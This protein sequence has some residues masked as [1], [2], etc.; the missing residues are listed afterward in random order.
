MNVLDRQALF[1]TMAR[2]TRI[3]ISYRRSETD[4]AAPLLYGQLCSHFGEANVFMDQQGLMGGDDYRR[5]IVRELQD[6]DAMVVVMGSNWMGTSKKGAQNRLHEPEDYVRF[7]VGMAIDRDILV[8]PVLVNDAV[9]PSKQDLPDTLW[10][11]TTYN[12]MRIRLN[13]RPGDVVQRLVASIKAHRA[14]G[15]GPS[16]R[17]P[18]WAAIGLVAM[19]L[20]GGVWWFGRSDGANEPSVVGEP[21]DTA[22][23][24]VEVRPEAGP[25][26][27]PLGSTA[28]KGTEEPAP[29]AAPVPA[30]VSDGLVFSSAPFNRD[31]VVLSAEGAGGRVSLTGQLGGRSVSA[32][33]RAKGRTFHAVGGDGD[34][35]SGSVTLDAD[36]RHLRGSFSVRSK[37]SGGTVTVKVDMYDKA[38]GR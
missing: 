10:R 29:K 12:D 35:V 32:S 6:C 20:V 38:R 25:V 11:L 31:E 21:I 4:G 17:T 3:F 19:A 34:L 30:C 28:T 36:C 15:K 22:R 33:L 27:T 9:R 7:E 37:A 13:D 1:F 23:T 2:R 18:H 5:R 14:S 16:L 26:N 8:I 24:P